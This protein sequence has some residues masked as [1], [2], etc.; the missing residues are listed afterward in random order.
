M[1][2]LRVGKDRTEEPPFH[3]EDPMCAGY[4]IYL[5][6]SKVYSIYRAVR[7]YP[8]LYIFSGVLGIRGC[9]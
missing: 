6:R 4:T 2:R 5:V 8:K 7:L 3:M 9:I 1:S